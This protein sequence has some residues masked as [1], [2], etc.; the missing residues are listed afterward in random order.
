[1]KC[2]SYIIDC[3]HFSIYK[4]KYNYSLNEKGGKK[5][6]SAKRGFSESISYIKSFVCRLQFLLVTH[7]IC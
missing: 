5:E 1:M 2:L 4:F 6:S 3:V 7:L